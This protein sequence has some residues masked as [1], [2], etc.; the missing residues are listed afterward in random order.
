MIYVA[1]LVPWKICFLDEGEFPAWEY[2]DY[3]IDFLFVIDLVL[4]FFTPI[5]RKEK[6][7]FS[8][9]VIALN[10]LKMWFWIDFFS[11][12]P[13]NL[14]LSGASTDYSILLRISKVPRLYRFMRGA[15]MLRAIKV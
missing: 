12:L 4:N 13:F 11:V 7:I 15:K 10:Y 1:T 8:H 14:L 3:F 9:K 2:F 5:I 6:I